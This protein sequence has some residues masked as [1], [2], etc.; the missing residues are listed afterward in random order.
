MRLFCFPP[1][2]VEF[3]GLMKDLNN[4]TGYSIKKSAD[5]NEHYDKYKWKTRFDHYRD[6][7]KSHTYYGTYIWVCLQYLDAKNKKFYNVKTSSALSQLKYILTDN[8]DCLF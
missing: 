5:N 7:L 2:F 1:N 4:F 8:S 3:C 6:S